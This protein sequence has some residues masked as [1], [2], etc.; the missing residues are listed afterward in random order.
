MRIEGKKSNLKDDRLAFDAGALSLHFAGDERVRQYFNDVS[1]RLKTGFISEVNLAEF[2]YKTA[3]KYGL[4]T[5]ETW[6]M[7]TRRSQIIIVP[8]DEDITREAAKLKLKYRNRLSLAD[9]FAVS[10]AENN[11]SILITTDS[12][13]KE[14]KEIKTVYLEI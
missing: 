11:D 1:S 12:R 14:A 7:L 8:P 6:Y 13:M 10:T 9:C 3:E 5:A 4:D 2:Y